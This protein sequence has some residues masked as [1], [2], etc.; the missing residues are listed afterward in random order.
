[1]LSRWALRLTTSRG[2]KYWGL[3]VDISV[4]MCMDKQLKLIIQLIIGIG[5]HL[6]HMF[7]LLASVVLSRNNTFPPKRY[8]KRN[9]VHIGS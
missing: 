2:S 6:V 5:I 3:R 8:L 9:L 1:M 4:G 7:S